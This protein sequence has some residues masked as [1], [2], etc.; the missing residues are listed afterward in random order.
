ML[1]RHRRGPKAGPKYPQLGE[2]GDIGRR[3]RDQVMRKETPQPRHK[4]FPDL[5]TLPS[6]LLLFLTLPRTWQV[7][8]KY[9]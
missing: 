5:S 8:K 6:L 7:L 9:Y 2:W 3:E 1:G 4:P